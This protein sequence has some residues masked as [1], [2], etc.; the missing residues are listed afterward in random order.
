MSLLDHLIVLGVPGAPCQVGSSG[1]QPGA[2]MAGRGSSG[3]TSL[4]ARRTVVSKASTSVLEEEEP[5]RRERGGRRPQGHVAHRWHGE[6]PSMT[7]QAIEISHG[8]G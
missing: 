1:P 7:A 4:S 5:E 2:S 8:A 3:S 6:F